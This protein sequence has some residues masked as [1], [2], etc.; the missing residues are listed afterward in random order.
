MQA[1]AQPRH[2]PEE[3]IS[4]VPYW[5]YSDP[6]IYAKEQER[7]FGGR[8][9]CYVCLETE[10]PNPGTSLEAVRLRNGTDLKSMPIE[11]VIDRIRS[12]VRDR[13]DL[14]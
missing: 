8:S 11:A 6:A 12:E 2:W 3:G 14:I 5:A 10:I 9:W 7:I 13:R 4:R 1:S